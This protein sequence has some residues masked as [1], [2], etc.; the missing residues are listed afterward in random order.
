MAIAADA[1]NRKKIPITMISRPIRIVEDFIFILLS[2]ILS[3]SW[4]GGSA[5]NAAP[6]YP[7]NGV[8]PPFTPSVYV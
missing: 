7:N 6:D 3:S 8:S 2:A 4:L 1:V 5:M